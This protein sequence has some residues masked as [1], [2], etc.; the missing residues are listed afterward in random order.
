MDRPIKL[1]T[2]KVVYSDRVPFDLHGEMEKGSL[3][4]SVGGRFCGP[5]AAVALKSKKLAE[6]YI[7]ALAVRRKKT[8]P[9][10]EAFACEVRT[11]NENFIVTIAKDSQKVAEK[12]AR[13]S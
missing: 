2:V 3:Y 11:T 1:F 13:W 4:I 12:L 7:Q 6:S 5:G 8:D 9:H 10:F